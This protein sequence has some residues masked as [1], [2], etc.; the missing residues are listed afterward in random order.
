MKICRILEHKIKK[1]LGILFRIHLVLPRLTSQLWKLLTYRFATLTLVHSQ[2]KTRRVVKL[3]PVGLQDATRW[4]ITM[5]Q[6]CNSLARDS[7]LVY[8]QFSNTLCKYIKPS[9][10]GLFEG[11]FLLAGSIWPSPFSYLKKN[12]I[13]QY[14]HNLMQVLINLFSVWWK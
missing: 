4:H 7:P 2:V 14:Q 12:Y 8:L 13:I 3:Q 1:I 5:W 10:I 9:K 11:S 6:T